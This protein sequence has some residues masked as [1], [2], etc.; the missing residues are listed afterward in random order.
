MSA[1]LDRAVRPLDGRTTR[2]TDAYPLVLSS[3]RTQTVGCSVGNT[4]LNNRPCGPACH[5]QAGAHRKTTALAAR[6]EAPCRD[7]LRGT[8]GF[9]LVGASAETLAFPPG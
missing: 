1:D 3:G 4:G 9:S 6:P 5:A 2:S 7:S 8:S